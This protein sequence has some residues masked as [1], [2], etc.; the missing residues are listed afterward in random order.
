M[1]TVNFSVPEDVKK[2]FDKAFAGENKSRVIAQLM[3][4]AVEDQSVQK[5]RSAAVDALLSRRRT[6]QPVTA[7]E[8]R[9]AREASRP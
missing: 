1:A 7:R 3:A 9:R 2:K 8:V 5:R 4:Q 6:K